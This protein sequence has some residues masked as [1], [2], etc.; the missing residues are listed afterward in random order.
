M[1]GMP[2]QPE[3]EGRQ[4]SGVETNL[5]AAA[6]RKVDGEENLADDPEGGEA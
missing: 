1:G 4:G 5:A 6:V 3:P 2:P